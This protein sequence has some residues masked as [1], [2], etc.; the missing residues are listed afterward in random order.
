MN[1]VEHL[2]KLFDYN[3]WAN[4]RIVAALKSN[5]SKKSQRILN[6]ILITEQEYYERLYGKDS[7]GFDFWQN[8]TLEESS[9]SAKENAGRFEK[10]L[11]RFDDEGLG[12]TTSYK[13]SEGVSHENNFRELLTHVLFHSATHR[14]N[15]IAKMREEGFTPPKIDYIIYLREFARK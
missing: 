4:R 12:Q 11:K 2:Q 15:I 7:T 13:T 5:E 9:D 10:L 3:D 1:T 14:G 8:L 6:H